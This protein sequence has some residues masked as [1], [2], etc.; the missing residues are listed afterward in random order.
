MVQVRTTIHFKTHH[1][2]KHHHSN[3]FTGVYY[4]A[5]VCCDTEHAQAFSSEA[6][7]EGKLGE[8]V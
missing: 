5:A 7:Q 8:N 2:Q 1:I 6:V 4:A 3:L